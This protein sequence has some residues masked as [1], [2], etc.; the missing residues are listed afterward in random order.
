MAFHKFP[1]PSGVTPEKKRETTEKYE[2]DIDAIRTQANSTNNQKADLSKFDPHNLQYK[3]AQ[4]TKTALDELYE[5]GAKRTLAVRKRGN[6]YARKIVRDAANVLSFA[7]KSDTT[8]KENYGIIYKKLFNQYIESGPKALKHLVE[9][10]SSSELRALEKQA[11]QALGQDLKTYRKS[12]R[13][14]ALEQGRSPEER[15]SRS[16][17]TSKSIKNA[18]VTGAYEKAKEKAAKKIGSFNMQDMQ[19]AKPYGRALKRELNKGNNT[20]SL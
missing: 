12:L 5:E 8:S 19:N 13:K 16:K 1:K 6:Q 18:S 2:S 15:T 11:Q 7:S 17:A 9:G 4:R 20:I 10:K 3:K 14:E